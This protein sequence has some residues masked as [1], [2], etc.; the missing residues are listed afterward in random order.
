[1]LIL[2]Y[3]KLFK[4]KSNYFK[5]ILRNFMSENYG[6]DCVEN[7][8][9]PYPDLH[10]YLKKRGLDHLLNFVVWS[11]SKNKQ[12][13]SKVH[14]NVLK[15]RLSQFFP[16]KCKQLIRNEAHVRLA[17]STWYVSNTLSIIAV[18][19]LILIL[20]SIYGHSI[21]V[22]NYSLTSIFNTYFFAT[23]FPFAILVISK[24]FKSKINSFLHYQRMREVVYVLETAYSTFRFTKFEKLLKPPFDNVYKV[25]EVID[26]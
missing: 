6:A 13:R 18:L 1:W 2:F 14:I 26:N 17:S 5:N 20:I 12:K 4:I 11:K 15:V 3:L 25:Q 24:Y 21:N 23:L 16:E 22:N 8:E 9:F 19:G 7:C 10:L